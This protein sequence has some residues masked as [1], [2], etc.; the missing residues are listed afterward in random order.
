MGSWRTVALSLAGLVLLTVSCQEP[1]VVLSVQTEGLPDPNGSPFTAFML[2]ERT[3]TEGT[4][5]VTQRYH[6]QNGDHDPIDIDFNDDGRADPVVAYGGE[7][8][9]VQIL[10]TQPNLPAGSFLSLT[11]DRL[12][13]MEDLSDLAVGDINNDGLWDI[14]GGASTGIWYLRHPTAPQTTTDL[15]Y[16]NVAPIEASTVLVQL[17]EASILAMVD[18]VL[19]PGATLSDYDIEVD[20]RFINVEIA[21]LNLDGHS[22]IIG[23]RFLMVTLTPVNEGGVL[24]VIEIVQGDISLFFNPGDAPDGTGW[25][26]TIIGE[27][28]WV[29]PAGRFD[30]E[31]VNGLIVADMDRDG[32]LDIVSAA[33]TD[34][35]VQVAWF[36]NPGP[37]QIAV[38]DWVQWRIGCSRGRT[39]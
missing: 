5:V 11:L 9:V 17:D 14:I 3:F 15:R 33:Q 12:R 1:V 4:S 10:L 30:R 26:L 25:P 24:E 22:D 7:T 8:A 34:N 6:P 18:E 39:G 2:I 27:P 38:E 21:D 36:E 16:W 31:G 20:S 32:D 29:D 13:D 35:N 28:E 37:L 19:P 23:S